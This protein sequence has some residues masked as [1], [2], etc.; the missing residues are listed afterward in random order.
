MAPT[1][2]GAGWVPDGLGALSGEFIALVHLLDA[3]HGSDRVA[4]LLGLC[5]LRLY[6]T[7]RSCANSCGFSKD[8]GVPVGNHAE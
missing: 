2:R 5:L 7:A 8:R 1:T 4:N 3:P 6:P